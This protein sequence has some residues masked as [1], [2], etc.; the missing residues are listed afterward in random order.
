MSRNVLGV[1]GGLGP[2]ATARFLEL[3]AR[4]TDAEREQDNVSMIV[5]NFPSIPDRTGYI[6]GSNLR[7]PLPGLLSVGRELDRQQ[8]RCIAIPCVTAH[9][10]YEELTEGLRSPILHGIRDTVAHLKEN[11]V[12]STGIMATDGTI[13]SG[14]FSQEL[15]KAGIRP[16]LPTKPRQADVMHLIYN[17]IKAGEAPE[18]ERFAAVEEELRSRGAET[19]IL[20]CTELSLIKRDFP[21][22]PGFLDSMEVLAKKAIEECGKPLR[23][24]YQCLIT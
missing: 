19:I 2:L 1:I 3:V 23:K 13:I 15:L 8:V 20:G 5:Y 18:M 17:N 10:F 7:S 22:N 21:L 11:G 6:L 9:F 16:V 4:M 12:S 14:L 24:K